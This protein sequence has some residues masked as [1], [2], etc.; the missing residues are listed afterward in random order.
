MKTIEEKLNID[1]EELQGFYTATIKLPAQVISELEARET[2]I[3]GF[4]GET[5]SATSEDDS[6]IKEVLIRLQEQGYTGVAKLNR[7]AKQVKYEIA[8]KK[9]MLQPATPE[10]DFH[11]KW[12][13]NKPMPMAIMEGYILEETK[14]MYRMKLT[15]SAEPSK[16]CRV[17]GATLKNKLS[18]LYGVGPECSE[19]IGLPRIASKD[20]LEANYRQM[21]QLAESVEWEG[22][23]IK[24]AL[25]EMREIIEPTTKIN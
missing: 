9:W 10:F 18:L 19:K 1:F 6:C 4:D 3:R 5:L 20:E 7:I 22:W 24:K 2:Y 16:Y 12:N 23:V 15:G 17:C 21:K 11:A 25:K 13:N 14:G 8:V